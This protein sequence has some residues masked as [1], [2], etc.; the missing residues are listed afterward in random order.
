MARM[1]L[2]RVVISFAACHSWKL[3]Q[4]DVKNAFVYGEID[5][6]IY[7]EQPLGYI[8]NSRLEFVCKLKKALYD[9][10]QAF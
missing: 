1:T 10:K 6:D 5:K 7:M 8:S 9:L 2:V 3:W 4:L